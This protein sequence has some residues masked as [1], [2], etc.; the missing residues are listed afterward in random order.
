MSLTITDPTLP[1]GAA[2]EST[3]VNPHDLVLADMDGVVIIPPSMA[4]E[5]IQ[6]AQK[7][8]EVDEKCMQDLKDGKGIKETFAKWRGK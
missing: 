6:L 7:G 1:A 4:E 8:R 3:T 5:V 2:F